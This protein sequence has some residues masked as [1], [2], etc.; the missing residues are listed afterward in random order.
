VCSL[1][2]LLSH[3]PA[4]VCECV[5]AGEFFAQLNKY[6][7]EELDVFQERLNG[8][9]EREKLPEMTGKKYEGR[10]CVT[11]F[12]QDNM[13][14]RG[15]IMKKVSSSFSSYSSFYYFHNNKLYYNMYRLIHIKKNYIQSCAIVF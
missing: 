15:H 1:L 7:N 2:V 9:Y 3:S 4:I 13:L 11:R 14:Y 10:Y 5:K 6:S 12:D 8:F